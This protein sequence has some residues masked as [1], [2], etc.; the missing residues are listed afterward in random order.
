MGAGRPIQVVMPH[1]ASV[2]ALQEAKASY[3]KLVATAL[4]S[5]P[6]LKEPILMVNVGWSEELAALPAPTCCP[7]LTLVKT[8]S[9]FVVPWLSRALP[10]QLASLRNLDI[11]PLQHP[12]RGV[13]TS[14]AQALPAMPDLR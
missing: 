2:L 8:Q 1:V 6:R 3:A 13:V 11:G 4:S 5:C 7:P 12:V 9:P 10:G 14:L